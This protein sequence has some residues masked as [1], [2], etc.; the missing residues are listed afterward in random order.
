MSDENTFM[1]TSSANAVIEEVRVFIE[2]RIRQANTPT[3]PATGTVGVADQ[4]SKL[5]ELKEQ[6][7]LSEQEFVLRRL[8]GLSEGEGE[9]FHQA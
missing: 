1:F 8:P 7:L 4:L 2:Q 3:A 6:G 5:A 9:A